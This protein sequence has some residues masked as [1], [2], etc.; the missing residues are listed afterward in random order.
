[1]VIYK[2]ERDEV[3]EMV[4]TVSSSFSIVGC[5][6]LL[7]FFAFTGR[8]K[9]F[10]FRIIACLFLCDIIASLASLLG[11]YANHGETQTDIQKTTCYVSSLMQQFGVWGATLWTLFVGITLFFIVDKESTGS[12]EKYEK[13]YHPICWGLPTATVI[14]MAALNVTGESG[15]WCWMTDGPA[16]FFIGYIPLYIMLFCILI[17]FVL[18][19]YK[20]RLNQHRSEMMN[21]FISSTEGQNEIISTYKFVVIAL[22]ICWLAPLANRIQNAIEPTD[23]LF[24]LMLLHAFFQPLQGFV[25]TVIFLM[26]TVKRLCDN[27]RS[28]IKYEKINDEKFGNFMQSYNERE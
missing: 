11:T 13:F 17:V 9:I 23:P 2:D 4:I 27:E 19:F 7:L 12:V 21:S 6:F 3:L 5:V 25:N 8:L 16:R 15:L 1:V 24:W 28:T 26:P 10:R 20:T 22:F 14:I 18:T